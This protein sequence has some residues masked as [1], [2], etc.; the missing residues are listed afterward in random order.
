M[1]ATI[2][3]TIGNKQNAAHSDF[4]LDI[5]NPATGECIARCP[6]SDHADIESAV[7]A[8]RKAFPSWSRLSNAERANWLNK[9]ADALEQ[10]L[11]SFAL[12]ETNNAGKPLA[13]SRD[14]EIPRAVE[15]LRF[16]AA[17]ASQF[18][19]ESHHGQAGWNVSTHSAL[20]IV[21]CISP[22]NLPLY[23]FTWK[24]APAL[25]AGNCVIAKPSEITPMTAAMLGELA[26]KIGFPEGVLNIVH[27]FGHKVGQALVEH[28][29]VKAI[30][31]TGST[32]IGKKIAA[33]CGPALKKT[34]LELGGKNP[35]IIF[36][37]APRK[38]LIDTLMR[39]AFQNS[40]QIC[41]CGSRIL[42]EKSIYAE[43]RD[44]LVARAKQLRV[45]D[46]T[47]SKTHMGSM[48]SKAHFEKVMSH[49]ELAKAEG[50]E[51][52]CGGDAITPAGRCEQGWFIAPTVFENL[53]PYT[54]SNQEEIFGPVVTLQTFDDETEAVAL[55]NASEY[56]L[57]ASIWTSDIRRAHHVA[58]S[59]ECGIIWINSWL[60]R[61]LRTP[62]GGMKQSGMGRE[63][64]LDAM[65][66]FTETKNICIDLG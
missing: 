31:F 29:D 65:R 1:L 48:I 35:T 38:N 37:D 64:G 50:G 54:R 61:D 10:E 21:G 25:A 4:W 52:L 16:F 9:L 23:L 8:A 34:S 7:I 20:G 27:G 6:D 55:A 5:M 51:L 46:P 53:G 28:A 12:A 26:Q 13:L 39:S 44:A 24:I 45:G 60:Q 42:I 59:V 57:A 63:G 49:I 41:L 47:D 19:S 58:N 62:F 43:I 22:W 3:N 66:F 18:S 40:G 2:Y 15:N 17:A 36:A 30:S 56:G 11:D 33:H 32:A 14:I